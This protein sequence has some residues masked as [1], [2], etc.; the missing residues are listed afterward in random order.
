M[1]K[2]TLECEIV[3]TRADGSPLNL[4]VYRRAGAL[5]I[6]GPDGLRHVCRR[7]QRL[8]EDLQAEVSIVFNATVQEIV[9]LSVIIAR[10]NS[11]RDAKAS[12]ARNES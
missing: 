9:P 10:T 1:G 4:T 5:I 7:V 2:E 8:P 12:S 11:S 6:H 3:A